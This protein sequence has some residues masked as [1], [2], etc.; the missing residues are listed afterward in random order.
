M[1]CRKRWLRLTYPDAMG[2]SVPIERKS[3]CAVL[4]LDRSGWLDNFSIYAFGAAFA[5]QVGVA[6]E[7]DIIAGTEVNA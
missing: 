5:R 4:D 6:I 1:M 3:L 2:R 7:S